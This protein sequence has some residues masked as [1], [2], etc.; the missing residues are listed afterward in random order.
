MA[1][2]IP[3]LSLLYSRQLAVT[4]EC[5]DENNEATA[6]ERMG[7]S[8]LS[9]CKDFVTAYNNSEKLK[10]AWLEMWS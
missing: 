10:S 5:R 3:L 1:L 4:S 8:V 6:A 7:E 9:F 2:G